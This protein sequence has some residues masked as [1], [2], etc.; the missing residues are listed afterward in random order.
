MKRILSIFLASAMMLFALAGCGGAS[1]P[2]E[3]T[4]ST[5]SG[6]QTQIEDS[7]EETTSAEPVTIRVG[8]PTAPPALPVIHMIEDNMLGDNVTIELDIWSAPEQLIAMVQGG[9]HDMFAFPLTVV[10]K[11]YNNGLGVRLMN[12]NTW[13]V[14]YFLTTDSDFQSWADLKGK[15]V[16]IPLQSSPPDAL[17]QYFLDEAGLKVGE[18]VEIIYASTTEVAS[19]LVSGQAQYATLIEP[20]V[21][22]AMTQNGEVIRAL[23]FESEWQRTTGTDTM[24]PN[25]GFGATQSFIETNP[26]LTAQFQAAYEESVQWVLD[27]PAEAADL[28]ESYLGM[29]APV[30]QKAI[31]TMGLCYKSAVDAKAELDTFYDLLNNFDPTMIG[32]KLPDDGMYY[33]G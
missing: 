11:L 3:D 20:Q 29:K 17:T 25:A 27:H 14:T 22:A 28:A 32:G 15:T 18:D 5:G 10:A 4:S 9:E 8:I 21:T 16:Y 23:S 30:V 1:Q 6:T 31:P 24:I 19:M 13:G 33:A 2:T 12:V 26:E 7:A